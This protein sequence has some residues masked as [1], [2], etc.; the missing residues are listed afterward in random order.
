MSPS[1]SKRRPFEV[2]VATLQK[3]LEAL[4]GATISD[5]TSEFLLLPQGDNFLEYIDFRSAYEA[6]KKRTTGFTAVTSKNVWAALGDDS[7]VF[8]VIR[9]MLGFSPPE[10]AELARSELGS[11]VSQANARNVDAACRRNKGYIKGVAARKHS[12]GYKRLDALVK[13][14]V[15]LLNDGAPETEEGVIHRLD[16]FDTHE[17]L[18]SIRHAAEEDV[19]YPVL[20]Y[21][22]YLGRP[23][24]S[25]RDSV[26]ELVGEIM[27]GAVE[28]VLRNA[29][30][31]FRKTKRA[32]RIRG[33]DQAPDFCIPDEVEPDVII[34]AK[35]TSDDGTARDKVTRILR[36]ASD[37]QKHRAKGR[38][39]QVIACID[40]RGFGVR[41][42]DMKQMLIALNGKVFTAATLD[43]ILVHTKISKHVT[44][45]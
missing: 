43:Q 17:G 31:T 5:L 11:D 10:W 29:G 13:I 16:K 14:A 32:E 20:L 28:E 42:E 27:E 24:A 12:V 9:A 35:I 40:G 30:V 2:D 3:D 25:H 26:S 8:C 34:E 33:F 44:K 22:R 21:E 38:D 4:A 41:R 19:P 7:R 37:S 36:L 18:P 45:P 1:S 6:L 15:R 39:Y 23:F